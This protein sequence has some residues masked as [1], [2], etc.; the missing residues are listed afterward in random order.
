MF[1]H[2]RQVPEVCASAWSGGVVIRCL[3]ALHRVLA[4]A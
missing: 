2:V 4:V 3:R 1:G